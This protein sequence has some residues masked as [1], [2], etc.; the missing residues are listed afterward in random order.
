MRKGLVR[1][2]E[3]GSREMNLPHAG[4]SDGELGASGRTRENGPKDTER[5]PS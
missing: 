1:D 5:D 3:A 2:F 4:P